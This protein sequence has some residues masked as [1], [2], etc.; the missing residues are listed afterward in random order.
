MKK[1]LTENDIKIIKNKGL[2]Y[3]GVY[4]LITIIMILT[5]YKTD[6]IIVGAIAFVTAYV[7]DIFCCYYIMPKL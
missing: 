1:K 5:N 3:L 6:F 7:I 4:L 2:M